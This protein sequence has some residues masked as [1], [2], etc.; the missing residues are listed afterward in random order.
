MNRPLGMLLLFA[1]PALAQW[2]EGGKPARDTAWRKSS[3]DFGVM[4]LMSDD[5]EKFMADWEKP[6]T[7][8]P[9]DDG[10]GRTRK[11]DRRVRALRRMRAGERSL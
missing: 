10:R 3:G 4:L 5:P 2:N 8:S 7:P 1:L 11:T 6:E 9:V